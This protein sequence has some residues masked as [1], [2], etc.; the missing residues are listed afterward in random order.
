MHDFVDY[1]AEGIFQG[2]TF[3]GADLTSVHLKKHAPTEHKVCVSG[4]VE[5][6]LHT[7]CMVRWDGVADFGYISPTPH[8]VLPLGVKPRKPRLIVWDA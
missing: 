6:L 5:S 1:T 8:M 3:R 2:Q 7:G 4:E